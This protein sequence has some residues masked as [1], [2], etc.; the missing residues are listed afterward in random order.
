MR[1]PL[2]AGLVAACLA[3]LPFAPLGASSTATAPADLA[4]LVAAAERIGEVQIL[5][6]RSALRPDGAIETRYL[7]ST[8]SPLKGGMAA[9]EEIVMPGGEVAGRGLLLPG[10]PR[11]RS[12][13][14]AILFLSAAAAGSG[15]RVPIGLGAGAYEVVPDPAGGAARVIGMGGEGADPSVLDHPSFLAAVQAEILRQADAR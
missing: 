2:L 7:V 14:R 13:Q 15:W 8:L 4:A 9:I 11:L 10:L 1:G 6:T 12:G 3:G 5:E